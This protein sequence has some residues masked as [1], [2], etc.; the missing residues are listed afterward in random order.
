MVPGQ[1]K[2]LAI[3]NHHVTHFNPWKSQSLMVGRIPLEDINKHAL[4]REIGL[5]TLGKLDKETIRLAAQLDIPHHEGAGGEEN[6][7]R[8]ERSVSE[9][10]QEGQQS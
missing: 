1:R 2:W 3:A 5:S 4:L 6:F 8:R 7:I 9:T 10:R